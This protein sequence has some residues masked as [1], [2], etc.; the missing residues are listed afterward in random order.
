MKKISVI[1]M[2]VALVMVVGSITPASKGG[3]GSMTGDQ[4]LNILKEGNERFVA[5]KSIYPNLD[6]KRRKET[7][8]KGQHPFATIITRS[9]SRV[10]PEML[11]D[12][13]IGDIFTIRVAGNVCN[14]DEAGSIEYGVDHLHTPLLVVLGH[15]HCGAV[16]AVVEDAKLHGN[17]PALVANI[18]PAAERAKKTGLK[19][20]LLIEVAVEEN[21]G[22]T[23]DDLLRKSKTAKKLSETGKVEWLGQ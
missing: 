15:T 5:G 12:Q 18:K 4:A 21:V 3:E 11:F 8:E 14:T 10:P 7:T 6:A 2:V 17:I 22:Q 20:E 1:V 23:I 13:G 9:D 19:D 16:T